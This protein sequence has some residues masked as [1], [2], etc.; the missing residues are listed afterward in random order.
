MREISAGARRAE[1]LAAN[2][3]TA[4]AVNGYLTVVAPVDGGSEYQLIG[5]LSAVHTL[6]ASP[7]WHRGIQ[8]AWG[9][10]PLL[11]DSLNLAPL[12]TTTRRI[13]ADPLA[14]AFVERAGRSVALVPLLDR[15][16]KY[17]IGWVAAWGMLAP[18]GKSLMSVGLLGLVAVA[19]MLALLL[20]AV[21]LP[22]RTRWVLVFVASAGVM[23]LAVHENH[24]VRRLASRREA[25][26][27]DRVHQLVERAITMPRIDRKHLGRIEIGP[28]PQEAG[29][30]RL[31]RI[32]AVMAGGFV[33]AVCVGAWSQTRG[34]R[35]EKAEGAENGT[36]LRN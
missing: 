30:T 15:D 13:L 11:S 17:P 6:A 2:A 1:F 12:D 8:V 31:E 33:L 3:M 26:V 36:P 10:S 16:L 25:M 22:N 32:L 18:E 34:H 23:L 5:L 35:I 7:R 20:P 27:L 24:R 19:G 14:T 4:R 29:W 21:L 9:N 28:S